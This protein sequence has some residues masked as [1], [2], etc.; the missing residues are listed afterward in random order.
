MWENAMV[1]FDQSLTLF[2]EKKMFVAT[3]GLCQVTQISNSGLFI[4]RFATEL[5]NGRG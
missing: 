4:Q 2:C 5:K 3:G 1:P